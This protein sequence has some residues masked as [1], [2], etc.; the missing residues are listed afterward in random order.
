MLFVVAVRVGKGWLRK[1]FDLPT[2]D[3]L[4]EYQTRE[5]K[6]PQNSQIAHAFQPVPQNNDI[7]EGSDFN[8]MS[9]PNT[10]LTEKRDN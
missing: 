5:A 8:L 2:A 10:S 3:R 6:H 4:T 9:V 7:V 1:Q